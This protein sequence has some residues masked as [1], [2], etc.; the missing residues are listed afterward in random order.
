MRICWR[1][2]T[3][4]ATA[5]FVLSPPNSIAW[6]YEGH[7]A[8]N[9]LA[10][11]TLPSGFP[12][13]VLT[14]EARERVAF[15]SGEPDRWRNT[16]ELPLRHA[17]LPDHYLDLEE[18]AMYGLNP[19]NLPV[20]RYEFVGE[21]TRIRTEHPAWFR[22]A[23]SAE[24]AART[25]ALIGLLPWTIAETYGKLQSAFS[26]L[27]AFQ[28]HGEPEEIQNA[29]ENVLYYMG[30]LGHYVGDAAQPLH[31]SKHYN[32]WVG[33]NPGHYTTNRTFHAWID[34]GYLRATGG[35]DAHDLE[36]KLRPARRLPA[37]QTPDGSDGLF[38]EIM[39]FILIQYLEVEPLY[40]LERE[41][42]LDATD[43]TGSEGRKQLEEQIVRGAQL[44]GDLYYSAWMNAPPDT[45]LMT[46]LVRRKLESKEEN[47]E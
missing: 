18:L 43:V 12:S 22:A 20:F 36:G 4:L 31:V 1:I 26:A 37:M 30:V 35:L 7:R 23:D 10:L 5:A 24:D 41:G 39:R 17:N 6:D 42:G 34:G 28:E 15:L 45:F 38:G 16:K 29:E 46:R 8:I 21:L 32:G 9:L 19:T 2:L 27:N 33:P 40:A 47:E 25:Q 44:L 3:G 14:A 13:F 11:E